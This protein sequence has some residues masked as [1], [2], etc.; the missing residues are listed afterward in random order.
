[1]RWCGSPRPRLVVGLSVVGLLQAVL[2][3]VLV[4]SELMLV[5]SKHP[6]DRALQR[7]SRP[8]WGWTTW[9][10]VKWELSGHQHQVTGQDWHQLNSKGFDSVTFAYLD[11]PPYGPNESSLHELC[12]SRACP[13][14][15][16]C[17]QYW[18]HFWTFFSSS[19]FPA[20]CAS[21]SLSL[22]PPPSSILLCEW[23]SSTGD[24]P[25]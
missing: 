22:S 17:W 15:C 6:E 14:L 7:S 13:I 4:K 11:I 5:N 24:I 19:F 12:F 1:M 3:S 25:V 10:G 23:N 20:F 8:A 9:S 16:V 21:V 18:H 2:C